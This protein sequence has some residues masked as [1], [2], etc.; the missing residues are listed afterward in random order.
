MF[1]NPKLL[2]V[3]DEPVIC[4]ACRRILLPHG[5]EVETTCDAIEGLALAAEQDFAV[6]LLD[7]KMVALD[8]IGFLEQ[9][10][11]VKPDVPVI[12]ITGYPNVRNAASAMRLGAADYIMK[13]FAPEQIIG[14]VER[15]LRER[16]RQPARRFRCSPHMFEPWAPLTD[17]FRFWNESWLQ[18]GED[19]SVRVGAVLTRSQGETLKAVKSPQI[20]ETVYQGLP[21]TVLDMAGGGQRIVPAPVSGVVIL[22]N[23]ELQK[24]PSLL[25]DNP[26]SEGWI[27]GVCPTRFEEEVKNCMP[28]RVI[29]V[30]SDRSSATDQGEKLRN[31]GCQVSVIESWRAATT[32]AFDSDT[33]TLIFD[34]A[35]FGK[36]GP[37]LVQQINAAN[38]S[39]KVIVVASPESKWEAAYRKH[40]ILYYAISP[41]TDNEM[42]DIL[43]GAFRRQQFAP[44]RTRRGAGPSEPVSRICITNGSGRRV[45]LLAA[46]RLLRRGEGLC[47]Q[48]VRRL[49]DHLYSVET[50]GCGE[51]VITPISILNAAQTCDRLV[52]LLAKDI[53]RPPGSL[54]RDTLAEFVTPLCEN[55]G[56]VTALVVQPASGGAGPVDFDGSTTGALAEHIVQEMALCYRS[57]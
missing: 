28:R 35:S 32:G 46:S 13:P 15:V 56:N 49:H 4:R 10:R 3:D 2:V 51:A 40:K 19:G 16:A 22:A 43:D 38:P 42:V 26:C 18:S 30:N 41:F 1:A 45:R 44:P 9:L 52:V 39:V 14:A 29:L 54:V 11:K 21:L 12:L 37:G 31:W 36:H 25:A 34:A 20:G 33:T 50:T 47:E 6:V 23:E 8:G 55:R 27:A 24:H 7:I 17:D 48:L 57:E 5:F 53:G